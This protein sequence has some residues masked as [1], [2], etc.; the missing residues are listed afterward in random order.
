MNK[1]SLAFASLTEEIY[2]G[3]QLAYKQVSQ[4]PGLPYVCLRIPTG[5]GK[6]LVACHA[7][8]IANKF[9]LQSDVSLVIWLVPSE[10][11]REQTLAALRNREHP[12]RQALDA[13]LGSVAIMDVS[14]ALFVT[15]PVLDGNTVIV[16]ATMQAFRR[17]NKEGL[18]VYR[19]NGALMSHFQGV[20]EEILR[21]VEPGADETF[22]YSLCNVFRV[23]K[24]IVIVDEAHNAR[25][26]LS[27]D[28]LAR[29]GPSCILEL[30]ATPNTSSKE[31]NPPS[32]VLYSVSAA[33][34]KAEN[35]IKLPIKLKNRQNW[36][37]LLG[38]AIGV[39]NGLEKATGRE[40]QQTGE[41]I[42]PIMLL[43]AQPK[44]KERRTVTVET[45]EKALLEDWRIPREQIARATGEDREIDGIDLAKPDCPIRYIIT[46]QALKEGWDCPF[47]YVLCSVAELKSA[48]A[49]EQILG[50]VLRLPKASRKMEPE[51]NAAYA[52]TASNSFAEAADALRDGLIENGFEK[53]EAKDLI[54][55]LAEADFD[56]LELFQA[57]RRN[58]AE[59]VAAKAERDIPGE[60]AAKVEYD[61]DAGKVK[62]I[63]VLT[64]GEEMQLK[65]CFAQ[66]A[67]KKEIGEACQRVRLKVESAKRPSER[68]EKF[69]VPYLA[70]KQGKFFEQFE[71]NHITDMGWT[72]HGCNAAILETEFSLSVQTQ[73]AIVDVTKKGKIETTFLQDL[74]AQ[75]VLLSVGAGWP[76]ARLVAWLD[77][78]FSHP[79]L[80]PDETGV[81][82]TSAVNHLADN[83]GLTLEHLTTNRYRLSNAIE[84]KVRQY[85]EQAQ[86]DCFQQFLSETFETPLTV[87]PKYSFQFPLD[88][89]PCNWRY[90]GG[91][92][93]QK[94]YYPAIG[95]LK[96]I[97]EEYDCAVF[98]DSLPEIK[99][100][101]RNLAGMG[102]EQTSF[103]LQTATD[104]F[105]PDF[106]CQL[107]DGRT[108]IV[109]Y[110][111]ANDWSNDD[112]KEK[113]S[114]G[115]LWAER[116]GGK[117]LFI[118]PKGP[119]FGKIRQQINA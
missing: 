66:A 70:I 68:N 95:E 21:D 25:T 43:Q 12:Y 2:E 30:T 93:F 111:N 14:E 49:V 86:R 79:D 60:L 103:W 104:K 63:A 83:R 69:P 54:T 117:C 22:D 107:N 99:W 118:M 84:K 42:R 114:L 26:G 29:L 88:A 58:V 72:L 67:S 11:I 46:V 113:R 115:E 9:L 119:E 92:V 1:A 18:L 37:E 100:W 96:E 112:N 80:S 55:P 53:Q 74:E 16:V 82:I 109:E 76:V 65:E 15:K 62:I 105:Y 48:T 36:Q 52:F 5:G 8:S 20:P 23:R 77:R 34:L 89:Y 19:T 85:R 61:R 57:A 90:I 97:G 78:S 33:E 24:P 106:V 4:L 81:F 64:P 116:S 47:A 94:H 7:V 101:V 108:F 17:E 50:R 13:E 10:A 41:Y 110:K 91:H 39:R 6:T 98:L 35:M 71:A 56:G 40:L 44:S 102:R 45:V 32:N 28:T 51:L 87:S 31:G 38:E 3:Q 73:T 59:T 75:M 27:F